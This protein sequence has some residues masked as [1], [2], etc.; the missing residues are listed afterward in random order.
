MIKE[1]AQLIEDSKS[2]GVWSGYIRAE[3]GEDVFNEM[4]ES[5]EYVKVKSLNS[6]KAGIKEGASLWAIVKKGFEKSIF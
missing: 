4:I 5:G 1:L 2:R 3:Y 6:L